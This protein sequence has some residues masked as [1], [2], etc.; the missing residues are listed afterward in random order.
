VTDHTNETGRRDGRHCP[1]CSASSAVRYSSLRDELF[2]SDGEW[3]VRQCANPQCGL[4]WLDPMPTRFQLEEAYSNYYTHAPAPVS[5]RGGKMRRFCIDREARYRHRKYGY[6]PEQPNGLFD[7]VGALLHVYRTE[8]CKTLPTYIPGGRLLDV[9]CGAGRY[10]SEMRDLG[11]SVKGVESDPVAA[12]Q[13]TQRGLDIF[14]GTLHDARLQDDSFD[15][16][17]LTQVIEHLPNPVETLKECTRILKSKGHV[18]IVTPNSSSLT[19]RLFG[20]NWRGLEPPRHLHI[21]SPPSI[22]RLLVDA[23]LRRVRIS[24]QVSSSIIRESIYLSRRVAGRSGSTSPLAGL[25][26]CVISLAAWSEFLVTRIRPSL[27]DCLGATAQ[28]V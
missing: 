3:I 12:R 9:G 18:V 16:V 27:A 17:V 8:G 15:V 22:S 5:H 2:G 10:L 6:V 11:W 4:M 23:G 24:P 7:A 19:H 20:R 1:L 14:C 13:A 26:R 25:T 28:K 21:F